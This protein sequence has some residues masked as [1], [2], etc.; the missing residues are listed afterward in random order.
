MTSQIR[1]QA[2]LTVQSSLGPRQRDMLLRIGN[3]R[4]RCGTNYDRRLVLN[5]LLKHGVVRKVGK[6]EKPV[7]QKWHLTD[8][9]VECVGV[10]RDRMDL[11]RG[12]SR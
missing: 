5:S 6:A 4:V 8:L 2:E 12:R 7:D 11:T 3:G 9:G 1:R 10:L